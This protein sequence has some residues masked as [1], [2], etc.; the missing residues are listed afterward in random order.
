ML[1]GLSCLLCAVTALGAGCENALPTDEESS[2]DTS[3]GR[4]AS[5]SSPDAGAPARECDRA[6]VKPLPEGEPVW[7]AEQVAACAAACP[8]LDTTCLQA[9]CPDHE[10]HL[11]CVADSVDACASAVGGPCRE[12]W[13]SYVCCG[14]LNCEDS[15]YSDDEL[16][17]CLERECGAALSAFSDCVDEALEDTSG[18]G[19][20]SR[21][22]QRC[23]LAPNNMESATEAALSSQTKSAVSRARWWRR[24]TATAA[25]T[26]SGVDPRARSRRA[27][28]LAPSVLR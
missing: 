3:S 6:Q 24:R 22:Q 8:E 1:R 12:T 9:E 21:A 2:P 17:T 25:H 4:D 14:R 16:V 5:D 11:L 7:S 10:Q 28:F 15:G 26:A 18:E 27:R 23:V 19:C 20:D 13:T